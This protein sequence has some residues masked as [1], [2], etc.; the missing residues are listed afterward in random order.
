M[1]WAFL[2]SDSR[3]AD[4]I[5]SPLCAGDCHLVVWQ[6]CI[7]VSELRGHFL[8]FFLFLQGA[9][10]RLSLAL[11][12][13]LSSTSFSFPAS[14]SQLLQPALL[15]AWLCGGEDLA[16]QENVGASRLLCRAHRRGA[17]AP[18]SLCGSAGAPWESEDVLGWVKSVIGSVYDGWSGEKEGG[19]VDFYV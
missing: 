19:Y 11:H 13:L 8:L 12:S 15:R 1:P 7:W 3:R 10:S 9:E 6:N 4:G 18:V 2:Q 14:A 17:V 16:G 5:A